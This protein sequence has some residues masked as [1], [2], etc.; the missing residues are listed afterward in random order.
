MYILN[1]RVGYI[2]VRH[3][4]GFIGS[5]YYKAVYREFTDASFTE[6][7]KRDERNIHR[8]ILGPALRAEVGEVIEVVFKNMASRP[9]S[10]HPH[11]VFYSKNN[12]GAPY[13]DHTGKHTDDMVTK[14]GFYVYRWL[15]PD[16]AGPGKS[17]PNC[18][19]WPY[20]SSVNPVKDVYAG[21]VG[22]III[23]RKGILSKDGK[24]KDHIDREI[25]LFFFLFDEMMS[26]YINKTTSKYA[27]SRMHDMSNS[28]FMAS[29]IMNSINGF[30]YGNNQGLVMYK[31]E[32]I[33]WYIFALGGTM[34]MHTVHFHGQVLIH[35][36][37][38]PT[39]VDV[40]AIFPGTTETL[41]LEAT[42][43]GTWLLHCHVNDHL[44]NGMETFYTIKDSSAG[45][46]WTTRR[47]TMDWRGTGNKAYMMP[48]FML[49]I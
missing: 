31:G 32:K 28:T 11:G 8:G 26:W 44:T 5:K 41:E 25:T 33:A 18:I 14:N 19:S 4:K 15:V 16:R 29:N 12:E 20:Y 2:F 27:P 17:D 36:R 24:R 45:G 7:K 22:N 35:K 23:C 3:D 30:I 6:P 37:G 9:Y 49:V 13:L 38:N 40:L 46:A 47:T 39:I 48:E 21:L 1:F 42:N 10:I 34:D 43:P